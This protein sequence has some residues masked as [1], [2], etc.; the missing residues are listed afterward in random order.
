MT[1][2]DRDRILEQIA[3]L[4]IPRIEESWKWAKIDAQ[5]DDERANFVISY[6][7]SEGNLKQMEIE[8][9]IEYLRERKVKVVLISDDDPRPGFPA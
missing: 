3:D 1:S 4:I 2:E 5:V 7:D 8:R 9:A 6:L